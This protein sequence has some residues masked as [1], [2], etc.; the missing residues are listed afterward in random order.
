MDKIE[1]L[2]RQLTP[3]ERAV[4]KDLLLLISSGKT[5]GLDIVKLKDNKNIYR[6]RK[7]DFRIIFMK[8]KGNISVLA[9]ER[10]SEKTYK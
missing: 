6:A 1:K 3:K 5:D 8:G 4:L 9:L 7:G 10:R 2:L